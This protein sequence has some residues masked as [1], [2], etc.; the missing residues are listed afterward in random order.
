M[1][2]Q[3][4]KNFNNVTLDKKIKGVLID[5][6]NT[7]YIY[8]PCHKEALVAV[9]EEMQKSIGEIEDFY[10]TYKKAQ[11]IVKNRISTQA[12]SHS[13]VL[14]FQNMFELLGKGSQPELSLRLE[15]L[16]W[17]V[18]IGEMKLVP[19]LIKFLEKYREK[20]IKIVVV[21]DMT[22][23]IQFKKMTTLKVVHLVDFVVTS[24]EAGIEK[25]GSAIFDVALE[26]AGLKPNNAIMIG[27]SFKK[28][29]EGAENM[30]MQSLLIVHD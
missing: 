22:T 1:A 19:G 29:I 21:S 24:E 26:K 14:Y 15:T 11:K 20:G 13:R 10:D 16:Y 28:D 12:A 7:F 4:I 23:S 3:E 5:F 17:D 9:A 27:D 6:D 25:P 18:F 30:G 2:H 8:E